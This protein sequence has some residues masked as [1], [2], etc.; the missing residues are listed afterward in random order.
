MMVKNILDPEDP[1]KESYQKNIIRGIAPLDYM[2]PMLYE[3]APC[4]S[5]FP[6]QRRGILHQVTKDSMPFL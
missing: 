6:K 2:K 5:K 3:N 1:K 4:Q